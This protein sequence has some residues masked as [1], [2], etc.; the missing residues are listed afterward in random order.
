MTAA[1]RQVLFALALATCFPQPA[2]PVEDGIFRL[3]SVAESSKLILVSRIPDKAKYVLD[4][5][6]AKITVDGKP[7]EFGTLSLYVVV[8]VKFEP[9]KIKKDK[10]ELDG[11]VT[12]ISI[13]TPDKDK[14]G[15]EP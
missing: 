8:Q 7:A 12:E 9:K 11:A 15:T 5:S 4:A 1:S 10:I 13:T 14:G 6:A 3:L 2:L